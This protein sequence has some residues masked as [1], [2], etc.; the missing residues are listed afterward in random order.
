MA[1]TAAAMLRR[2]QAFNLQKE[3]AIILSNNKPEIKRLQK[4]Q[5]QSGDRADGSKMPKY[6]NTAYAN[7]KKGLHPG[8]KGPQ[9]GYF[10]L[11]NTSETIDSTVINVNVSTLNISL[12]SDRFNWEQRLQHLLGL[13]SMSKYELKSDVL[14]PQIVKAFKEKTGAK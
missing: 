14:Q 8:N 12:G 3:V 10:D 13:N 5:W 1:T 2:I 9:E 4:E 6:K 7:Y 11:I